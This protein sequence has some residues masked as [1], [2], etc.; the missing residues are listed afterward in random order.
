[1]LSKEVIERIINRHIGR[2]LQRLDEVGTASI[3]KECVK[4]EMWLISDDIK[5]ELE[6]QQESNYDR[7]ETYNE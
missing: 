6:Q 3:I 5:K 1:M 2:V 4:G 7:E